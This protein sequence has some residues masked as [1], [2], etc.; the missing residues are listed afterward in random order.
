MA[1]RVQIGSLQMGGN[2]PVRLQSMTTTPTPDVAATVQQCVTLARAGAELIRITTRTVQEAEVL[3]EIKAQLRA[4]SI[5]VPLVA[6]VHFNAE[7]AMTA[8]KY[9]EKVRINP[10]NFLN[11]NKSE[12][13]PDALQDTFFA[14]LKICKQHKTALRIGVNH[15]SL[16]ERMLNLYGDTPA[17]MVESAME[18][19]RLCKEARFDNVVVSMKAS[20]TR[21]MVYSTRL[22]VLAMER[23]DMYFP[24]HL[25]VT[26]AGDGEDGRIKSAVGI[27]TLLLEGLGDTIRVSLTEPPEN[28]IPVAQKLVRHIEDSCNDEELQVVAPTTAY[29]RRATAL[30]ASAP[31]GADQPVSVWADLSMLSPVYSADIQQLGFTY[32]GEKW[33]ASDTSPDVIYIGSATMECPTAGLCIIDDEQETV[34]RC[35]I[36]Y[37]NPDFLTFLQQYPHYILLLE[38]K[39]GQSIHATRLFFKVLEKQQITNPVVMARSYNDKDFEAFQ[40]KSAADCGAL[41]LDGYGDG[42]M[43]TA[44]FAPNQVVQTAFG[45]LQAAQV[46]ISKTEYI[47]CPGCGRTLYDIQRTLK[48]IKAKTAHLKGVK[49]AVMGCIV[50]GPGEMADADYGYVGSGKNQVSLYKGKTCVQKNIP[51]ENAVEALIALIKKHEKNL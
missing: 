17:G 28:E 4:K 48:E 46:R 25:G 27:G 31:T 19:L 15:G 26:E 29:H 6:D 11:D 50:N 2:L 34:L 5:D 40:L 1:H 12:T 42:L 21:V 22:L 45:I 35:D 37:I 10:G 51:Q 24:L 47:A 38:N 13:N 7:V 33:T 8:A 43:L 16:S 18:Y 3:Q 49:I 9:V 30:A 44:G 41:L 39:E 32:D 36:S 20:S 14:L 23:E